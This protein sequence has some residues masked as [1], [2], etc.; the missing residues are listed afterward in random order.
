MAG[1]F[2]ADF[3]ASVLCLILGSS[4][5]GMSVV[6]IDVYCGSG[7]AGLRRWYLEGLPINSLAL[8]ALFLDSPVPG[9]TLTI[10]LSDGKLSVLRD[11]VWDNNDGHAGP[12]YH[13]RPR[14]VPP[15]THVCWSIERTL[16]YRDTSIA[17]EKWDTVYIDYVCKR[18]LHYPLPR[19]RSPSGSS[20][21]IFSIED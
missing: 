7:M 19:G 12:P 11:Y 20:N 2:S 21:S 16:F 10:T 6:R 17:P 9:Q 14:P 4:S 8:I 5:G 1:F 13:Y 3:S 18:P 15:F